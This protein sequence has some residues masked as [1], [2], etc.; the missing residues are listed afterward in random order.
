MGKLNVAVVVLSVFAAVLLGARS[1]PFGFGD[2]ASPLDALQPMT[3]TVMK[4]AKPMTKT[5]VQV[6]KPFEETFEQLTKTFNVVNKL[7]GGL[8]DGYNVKKDGQ[9]SN[10]V[11]DI[12]DQQYQKNA[13]LT[14][15]NIV[16]EQPDQVPPKDQAYSKCMRNIID[17]WGKDKWL[18]KMK[19]NKDGS[20]SQAPLA[21]A[22]YVQCVRGQQSQV[23]D[24]GTPT[25]AKFFASADRFPEY[26]VIMLGLGA[27]Y[28]L[29]EEK[30]SNKPLSKLNVDIGKGIPHGSSFNEQSCISALTMDHCAYSLVK[31]PGFINSPQIVYTEM[32]R[33]HDT[34]TYGGVSSGVSSD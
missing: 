32:M 30:N 28:T 15:N 10:P 22:C 25:A 13:L 34:T 3:D 20:L 2:F 16:D 14:L 9:L 1:D 4:V 6:A 7:L 19:F 8:L 12:A 29:C 18:P 24:N 21:A 26:R 11:I 27:R 23:G 33:L 5:V 31:D 17:V